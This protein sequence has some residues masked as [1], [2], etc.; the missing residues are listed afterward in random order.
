M[1][2]TSS[3]SQQIDMLEGPM[4][5]KLPELGKRQVPFS[6][7]I[8][9]DRADFEEDPPKKFFRL[10]PNGEVRLR[11]GYVLT[12]NEVIKDADGKVVEL[13]CSHDPETRQGA[14]K[15]VKGIIHWV[16]EDHSA[17]VK[18]NLYDRLFNAPDPGAE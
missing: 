13:R 1:A 6:R 10:K 15:K 8:L 12:C 2:L 7:N 9:I 16:S 14:G 11:F 3:V 18:V 17:R 4:H 5:P